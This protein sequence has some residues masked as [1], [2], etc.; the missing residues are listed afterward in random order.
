MVFGLV[1]C[2][3]K[4]TG[5]SLADSGATPGLETLKRERSQFIQVA[6]GEQ[7][8]AHYIRYLSPAAD[9]DENLAKIGI[10][11]GDIL[12]QIAHSVAVRAIQ[13]AESI[14]AL[15]NRG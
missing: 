11:D 13:V 14:A 6:E 4:R 10:A 2:H 8:F 12:A 5:L 7:T 1:D 9:A 15:I 3:L